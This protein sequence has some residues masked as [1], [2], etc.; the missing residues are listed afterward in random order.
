M[1]SN[2]LNLTNFR[3]FPGPA[4][5]PVVRKT[6]NKPAPALLQKAKDLLKDGYVEA[7]VN[8]VR[9]AFEASIRGACE[10]KGVNL[11]FK[12][13]IPRPEVQAAIDAVEAFFPLARVK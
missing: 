12:P 5:V 10:I 1:K 7:A 6:E 13:N 3:A 9:Q 11:A 4:P 2:T 8:Y